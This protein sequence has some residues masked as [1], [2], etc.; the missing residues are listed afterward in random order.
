[1]IQRRL[2]LNMAYD[3]VSECRGGALKR[4]VWFKIEWKR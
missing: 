2:L 1:Q 3:T 4:E